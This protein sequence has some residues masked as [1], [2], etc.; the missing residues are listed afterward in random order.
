MGLIFSRVRPA[1]SLP[2]ISRQAE[3]REAENKAGGKES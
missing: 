1:F 3:G 2:G